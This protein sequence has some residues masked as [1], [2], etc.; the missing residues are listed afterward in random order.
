MIKWHLLW[1]AFPDS[2]SFSLLSVPTVSFRYPS[3]GSSCHTALQSVWFLVNLPPAA[4][5]FLGAGTMLNLF[6]PSATLHRVAAQHMNESISW[7]IRMRKETRIK[8]QP[9]FIQRNV[10]RAFLKML[11]WEPGRSA[12]TESPKT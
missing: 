4:C 3:L 7:R 9:R 12:A 6:S 5:E 1:E 11:A 8:A 10:D 2:L